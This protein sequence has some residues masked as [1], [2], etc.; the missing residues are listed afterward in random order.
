MRHRAG[1]GGYLE[2]IFGE[3]VADNLSERGSP[4]EL[5]GLLA[6]DKEAREAHQQHALMRQGASTWAL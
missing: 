2:L 5:S 4:H 1:G 3:V 6:G